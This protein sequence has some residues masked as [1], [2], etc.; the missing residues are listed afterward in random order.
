MIATDTC[1]SATVIGY[2]ESC[3]HLRVQY[4]NSSES[5]SCCLSHQGF[6]HALSGLKVNN[7]YCTAAGCVRN[8]NFFQSISMPLRSREFL[9]C[10]KTKRLSFLNPSAALASAISRLKVAALK[11]NGLQA[12]ETHRKRGATF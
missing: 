11:N 3:G 1:N 2:P 4:T 7:L 12:L 8:S 10:S 6:W 5:Q 9:L